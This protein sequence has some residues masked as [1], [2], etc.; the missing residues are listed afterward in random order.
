MKIKN[1]EKSDLKKWIMELHPLKSEFRAWKRAWETAIGET[2]T[3]KELLDYFYPLYKEELLEN[4]KAEEKAIIKVYENKIKQVSLNFN[5][6]EVTIPINLLNPKYFNKIFGS[7]EGSIILRV[8]NRHFTLNERNFA[9]IKA[10]ISGE[11]TTDMLKE[12][13]RRLGSLIRDAENI[14]VMNTKK[15]TNTGY[16]MIDSD[17]E[18]QNNPYPTGAWFPYWNLTDYDLTRYDIHKNDDTVKNSVNCL[19][20]ALSNAGVKKPIIQ[21]LFQ[22]IKNREVPFKDLTKIADKLHQNIKLITFTKARKENKEKKEKE[23]KSRTTISWKPTSKQYETTIEIC[24]L[25]GHYFL[26]EDLKFNVSRFALLNWKEC[27]P[28]KNKCIKRFRNGVPNY[29]NENNI[30]NSQDLVSFLI[31]NKTTLLKPRKI[32]QLLLE[33]QY[34]RKCEEFDGLEFTEDNYRSNTESRISKFEKHT[35]ETPKAEF[36][37]DFE[38]VSSTKKPEKGKLGISVYNIETA[39]KKVGGLHEEYAVAW[40]EF[41][42]TKPTKVL[43]I[44]A[45]LRNYIKKQK[46][47]YKKE[48]N[49]PLKNKLNKYRIW[50]KNEITP[51]FLAYIAREV[52]PEGGDTNYDST[53]FVRII[54]HNAGYDCRFIRPYLKEYESIDRGS[55]L[56]TAKGIFSYYLLDEDGCETGKKLSCLFQVRDSLGLIPV[57]LAKFGKLFPH[58][59][60]EKEIIPY[61]FY[62][63]QNTWTENMKHPLEKI[64]KCEEFDSEEKIKQFTNNINRWKCEKKGS[65]DMIKYSS[66]YCMI[67]CEVLNEGLISY[68]ES[69]FNITKD[70]P[71]NYP[72]LNATD[73]MTIPSLIYDCMTIEGCLEDTYKISGV[74]QQYIQRCVVGGRCMLRENKPTYFKAQTL[75]NSSFK[76]HRHYKKTISM[77]D[78]DAV[79]CY[80]SAFVRGD[81]M[82]KGIPKVIEGSIYEDAFKNS[83]K[84]LDLLEQITGKNGA[85]FCRIIITKVGKHRK[86]PVFSLMED[87]KRQWSTDDTIL[88]KTIYTDSVSLADFIEF[89]KIEFK[90]ID[91]YYFDEGY[92]TKIITFM[93]KLFNMRISAKNE[94][95][96][97]KKGSKTPIL[98]EKL[99]WTIPNLAN[100]AKKLNKEKIEKLSIKYP[101]EKGY[102]I[103]KYKNSIQEIYKLLMN[104]C[105]G[106]LL[107]KEVENDIDYIPVTK[108]IR[109]KKT[110]KYKC[111]NNWEKY[112]N[113]N[114]NKIKSYLPIPNRKHPTEVR[115]ETWKTINDHFNNVHQGVLCLSHSK[116]LMNEVICLAEDKGLDVRYSDT[117]SIHIVNEDIPLLE[118][119]FAVRYN[120]KVLRGED[121]GQFNPDFDT[122]NIVKGCRSIIFIG[123]A[124]KCYIDV[125][126]GYDKNGK[127][128]T[129]Y[130]IRL[131]GVPNA[132][133]LRES[134]RRGITP[135]ELYNLLWNSYRISFDLLKK[136]NNTLKVRFIFNDDWTITNETNFNRSLIF[137][138]DKKKEWNSKFIEGREKTYKGEFK[139]F[140]KYNKTMLNLQSETEFIN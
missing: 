58:I 60:Q 5:A 20:C 116:R 86:F 51:R 4:K 22:F 63:P 55:K 96:V 107:L 115:V 90:I 95:Q 104:C 137:N 45:H 37:F 40:K 123:L 89:Q 34:Y 78:Y 98:T 138:N 110:N 74:P 126:E 42:S 69:I 108:W 28:Y 85:F 81:G 99:D 80:T 118:K 66:K 29:A 102:S 46:D 39:N 64:L 101:K 93:K 125:L 25:E 131:K 43:T 112:F 72:A 84:N 127:L 56:I 50:N 100:I 31:L 18:T 44:S 9:N 12:S 103:R 2:M 17:D 33:S 91:G 32:N 79:S 135:L 3:M 8:G 124:K 30:I 76:N 68:R 38:T 130:H 87:D 122:E 49:P 52:F 1:K 67:D 114:Q 117:D 105:Y 59:E 11:E 132:S 109:D 53:E 136:E 23:V 13:D 57:G 106:K 94:L 70:N 14:I 75:S 35:K 133:I 139:L 54:A 120:G 113:R 26:K 129:E 65:I 140:D 41:A 71:F 97:W 77:E 128:I 7:L 21:S 62:T 61:S 6:E 92:N 48:T 16:Q 119:A 83:T 10:L 27:L 36:L 111:I 134:I 82:L 47:A 15:A 73:Y 19:M 121:L 24:C 88:N